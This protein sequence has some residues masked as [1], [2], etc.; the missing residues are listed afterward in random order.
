MNLLRALAA[1][2]S[3]TLLSRVLGFVRGSIPFPLECIEYIKK[4][5]DAETGGFGLGLAGAHQIV[6]SN[7]ALAEALFELL[8]Q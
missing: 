7:A 2:S 5:Q 4:C 1:V 8:K 3:M 6:R